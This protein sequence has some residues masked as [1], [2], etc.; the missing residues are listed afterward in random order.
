MAKTMSQN[1]RNEYLEKMRDRYR[2]RKGRGARS[3]LIDE[4][5]SVTG[6]ERKY[7]IKLLG[8]SRGPNRKG[9]PTGRKRGVEKTY[10]EEV[11]AVLFEIWKESEQP[12]GK[13]LA[14]MLSDWLPFHEKHYGELPDSIKSKVLAISPAQIDRVLAPKKVGVALRKRR[15]PRSNAAMKKLIPIRAESWNAKEPGWLEADTVAHC[16]G[17]M[18]ESFVWSLTATD[19]YSGWT[20]V[21]PSWNRGQYNVSRAFED[22]DATLPFAILGVDTDNGREFLNYH[23]HHHFTQRSEPV[24]MTRSRPY[25][26]ND[27]AHVEQK[28]STHVRQLLGHDRLGYEFLVEPID[29][30]AK[31]WCLWRNYFTTSFKQ[32]SNQREGSRTV[33][34]HEKIPQTPCER[35]V[36][37][38]RS[39]GD[40]ATAAAL[41][42]R[43]G[44]IDPIELKR[45]IEKKLDQI[46]KLDRALNEAEAE[47]EI[48]LEGVARPFLQGRSALRSA[49]CE[50]ALQK[51][52]HNAREH[53]KKDHPEPKT[54]EA[55]ESTKAA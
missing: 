51:R 53:L 3:M 26:K 17:D 5:C 6:H 7:A 15:P 33:R 35:L 21:R 4:F 54:K 40:E 10:D 31:A 42:A 14:P 38:C 34:K 24:E 32:I 11:V 55:T 13:R 27:Q 52:K 1:A 22:I 2:R 18:G 45:W 37:Y 44:A 25:R 12:S 29:E 28:N 39:V 43:K 9:P 46:W 47:G 41:E 30:L 16:G 20:E 23:L 19:I 48:D 36:D 49:P 8:R 50:P